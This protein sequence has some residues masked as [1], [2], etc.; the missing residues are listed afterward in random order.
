MVLTR[1]YYFLFSYRFS[2]TNCPSFYTMSILFWLVNSSKNKCLTHTLFTWFYGLSEFT[3][4]SINLSLL[5]LTCTISVFSSAFRCHT[6]IEIY[7]F[8]SLNQTTCVRHNNM[9]FSWIA[10]IYGFDQGIRFEKLFVFFLVRIKMFSFG[11]MLRL[12]HN[13]SSSAYFVLKLPF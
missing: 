13:S 12:C 2:S 1:L 6:K 10:Y 9:R 11:F 7:Q 4:L 8:S 5:F 3:I